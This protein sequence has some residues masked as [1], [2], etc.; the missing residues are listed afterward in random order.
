[1]RQ[2]QAFA[3]TSDEKEEHE[4]DEK[5]QV[6]PGQPAAQW[7]PECSK[8]RNLG[9]TG[10]DDAQRGASFCTVLFPSTL[11]FACSHICCLVVCL[12]VCL[13]ITPPVSKVHIFIYKF[14]SFICK[15]Y[16]FGLVCLVGDQM[17]WLFRV[18]T[19]PSSFCEKNFCYDEEKICLDGFTIQA[20]NNQQRFW[21]NKDL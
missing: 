3:M 17:C 14:N 7:G 10:E 16:N 11:F 1:M 4:E 19:V 20:V 15:K 8:S 13:F 9:D 6:E 18:K 5:E 12:F 2:V 21:L